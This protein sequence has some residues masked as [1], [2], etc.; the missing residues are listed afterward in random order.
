[1]RKGTDLVLGRPLL[2][3]QHV[4]ETMIEG[5]SYRLNNFVGITEGLTM[6]MN[7]K[8]SSIRQGGSLQVTDDI[9]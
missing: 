7:L 3:M 6:D 1:M 5:K 8:Y 2:V 4:V 9:P